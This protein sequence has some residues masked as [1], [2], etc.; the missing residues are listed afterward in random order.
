MT[1]DD[2]DVLLRRKATAEAL[3]KAGYPTSAAT[4]ATM[5]VRGGGP[6]HRCYGRIPLYR[7]GDALAWAEGR[8]SPP[9]ST[10]SE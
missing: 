7:W 4:L 3:S 8:M 6:I 5:A 1:P 10:T 2:P 9:R